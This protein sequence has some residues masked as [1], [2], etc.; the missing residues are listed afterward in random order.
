[1]ETEQ[2]KSL[3][4]MLMKQFH[5]D[6]WTFEF[7]YEKV[8]FGCCFYR[9]R[10]ISMSKLLVILNEE[11]VVKDTILHEIAHALTPYNGHGTQW[12]MYVML[13][14]VSRKHVIQCMRLE[15]E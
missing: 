4:L 9:Q 1:V 14:D 15:H 12:R 7:D 3:A 10:K 6:D 13:L 2:C 11:N 5:L 8:R